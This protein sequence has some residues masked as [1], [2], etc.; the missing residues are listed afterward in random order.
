MTVLSKDQVIIWPKRPNTRSKRYTVEYPDWA[1]V[2]IIVDFY[3]V[4]CC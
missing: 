2:R 3:Q 1:R 4:A